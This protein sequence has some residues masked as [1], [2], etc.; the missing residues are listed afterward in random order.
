MLGPRFAFSS[1]PAIRGDRVVEH[2]KSKAILLLEQPAKIMLPVPRKFQEECLLMATM[3]DVPDL[4]RQKMAVAARHRFALK[5]A[6][7]LRKPA[8]KRFYTRNITTLFREI[9]V[10]WWSDRDR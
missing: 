7:G 10:M 4:A 5:R 1:R 9:N 2:T 6:F 3:R 8:S